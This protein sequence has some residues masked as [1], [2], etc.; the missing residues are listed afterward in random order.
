VPTLLLAVSWGAKLA[1]AF[2]RRHAE[3]IDGL[4]LL[5]PGL[6]TR[7]R[8][9]TSQRILLRLAVWVGL[10]N[11]R[12]PIPLDDPALFTDVPQSQDFIRDDSL[13]LH[14]VTMG[15]L[16]ESEKLDRL[17]QQA[18]GEVHLPTLLML[19]GR[20][21]IVDNAATKRFFETLP[22]PN[23]RLIEYLE[24]AHT[25]EFEADPEPFFR[26]LVN[27]AV[28]TS[29]GSMLRARAAAAL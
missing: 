2:A 14:Q 17:A 3:L 13:A 18:A 6:F 1:V 7:V 5:Y 26:D 15:F 10:R 12:V 21:R 25:L 4:G 19:A 16:L 23:K 9:Q 11:W 22:S 28:A 24:A 8:P 20:D 29:Q 27:W